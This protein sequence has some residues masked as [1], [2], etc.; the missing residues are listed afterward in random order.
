MNMNK[1]LMALLVLLAPVFAFAAEEAAGA[2]E[3]IPFNVVLMA[4]N[5]LI[6]IGVLWYFLRHPIKNYFKTREENFKQAL[7][8]ADSAR[9]EAQAQKREVLDRLAKLQESTDESIEQARRDA[10]QIKIKIM[11]EAEELSV[12]LREDAT[13]TTHFEIER[14]KNELRSTLLAESVVIAQTILSEKIAETDQKRLQTEF[15]DKIQVVRS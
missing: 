10:Q 5:F 13:R 2:S 1:K 8:K 15:V 14:A 6:Y 7:V 11:Q 3:S 4:I 12:K 9:H